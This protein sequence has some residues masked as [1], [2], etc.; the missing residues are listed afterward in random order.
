MKFN[1]EKKSRKRAVFDLN[2]VLIDAGNSEE[3]TANNSFT[4]PT[5]KMSH[6]EVVEKFDFRLSSKQPKRL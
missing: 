3:K 4:S 5:Y 6:R 1:E 2:F